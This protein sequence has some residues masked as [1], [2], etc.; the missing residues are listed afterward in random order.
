MVW[1]PAHGCSPG[2]LVSK[3]PATSSFQEAVKTAA[4]PLPA[5]TVLTVGPSPVHSATVN[6]VPAVPAEGETGKA[7]QEPAFCQRDATQVIQVFPRSG[8]R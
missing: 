3:M 7:P 5:V 6:Q 8:D 4:V 1:E 2:S